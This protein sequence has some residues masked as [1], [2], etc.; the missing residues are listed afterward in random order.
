VKKRRTSGNGAAP[1][2]IRNLVLVLGDQLDRRSSAFD[3]FSPREDAVWM[4][5]AA[6]EA[7]YVPSHKARIVLFLSAMRHF[8]AALEDEGIA[9]VYRKLDDPD[10]AGTLA[11]ELEAAAARLKPLRL[12]IVEPGEWRVLE[13]IR[14]AAKKAGADLEIRED[15]HFLASHDDFD[16][17][18][19]GRKQ[20]RME[21]FY[22][23]MRRRTGLLMK[24]GEPEGGRWNYD[25]DNRG[26]FP[27]EGPGKVP[28]P[29]SFLP[30]SITRDVIELVENRF[31]YHPGSLRHFDW[32]V[33]PAQ[34]E[35][36]LNDFVATRLHRFGPYE[37]A[38]W[39]GQPWL[40]HSRLSSSMN[41]KLLDPR[42]AARAAEEAW[43]A[44]KVSLAGA[45]G[46]IRQVIGWREYVRGIYWRH[47]PGY[48]ELNALE[49]TLP[50]PR[51]YW[52][53][54]AEMNCLREVIGQ[55]LE[56][57]Y[58][59]HIQRLMVTGLFALLLGVAPREV[60]RWYLAVYVDAVEWVEL[61]NT[62][63]MSQFAD[64]G[65]MASKPYAASGKYIDRMSNYCRGCRYDPGR[66]Q[67][68]QACPFSVLYW[69]FLLRNRA[70]LSGN[71]RMGL[72]L[73][74]AER[75]AAAERKRIRRL[76]DSIRGAIDFSDT[77]YRP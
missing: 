33:T 66:I 20:L 64:G 63:G 74:N 55:T 77:G 35:K 32:P 37:D 15:R 3:G 54:Q 56:Y 12:I 46:F 73:R 48:A 25:A 36:A 45:E 6:G 41:L 31:S 28:A 49:A 8:R 19:Q 11:L 21:F 47:M 51:F 70:R 44:G 29:V 16:R 17:F 13:D 53:G 30:D 23:E 75:L 34:A 42:E 58:A 1:K 62:L 2:T 61:P 43:R 69:E 4:A 39:T 59:H 14:A 65:I 38:L 5:E 40:Y 57:G 22:R 68:S 10:N 50:L 71:P 52:T 72:Q 7:G 9:V 27:Q 67:G 60:H 24:G 18:A 76:A 26:A